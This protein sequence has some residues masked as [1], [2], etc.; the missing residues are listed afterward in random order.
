VNGLYITVKSFSR[1]KIKGQKGQNEEAYGSFFT[2][3]L[4]EESQRRE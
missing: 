4:F 3:V 1:K 2:P